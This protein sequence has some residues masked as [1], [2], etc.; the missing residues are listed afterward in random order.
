MVEA[1]RRLASRRVEG[2]DQLSDAEL[3]EL[4]K[5]ELPSDLTA[6]R[7]L[8]IRYEGL[9]FNTCAKIIGSKQ[10]AE[11]VAQDA[12]IQVFHKI[13]QFEG[14]SAFKT[15]L[16]KIVHNYC[17]N[18][19]S[20]LAR[21]RE[22]TQEYQ[23][24]KLKSEPDV[25]AIDPNMESLSEQVQEAMMKMKDKEREVLVMKFTTGMTIQEISDVLEIGLSAAKMRLYRS[26]ESFKE[27]YQKVD[28]NSLTTPLTA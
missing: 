21:K 22:K 1:L 5:K 10:D 20:K 26:L 14:R 24:M 23:E 11:E 4:C 16:Y 18:R 3:V 12:M 19:I 17:R 7:E 25:D 9:V 15:W 6:Y 13:H 28:K 2:L 8:L 27:F